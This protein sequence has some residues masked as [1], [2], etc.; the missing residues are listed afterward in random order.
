MT[1]EVIDGKFRGWA[2]RVA[3]VMSQ[4]HPDFTYMNLAIRGKLLGQVVEDQVRVAGWWRA[5]SAIR[6]REIAGARPSSAQLAH[7][8]SRTCRGRGVSRPTSLRRALD[9]PSTPSVD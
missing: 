1:D 9:S 2:D 6:V 3:D 5:S 7:R 8:H 4:A